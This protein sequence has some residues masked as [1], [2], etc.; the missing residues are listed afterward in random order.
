MPKRKKMFFSCKI[1]GDNEKIFENKI[2][3]RIFL[4]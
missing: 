1:F 3:K 4:F 2:E